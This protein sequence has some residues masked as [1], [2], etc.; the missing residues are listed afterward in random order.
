MPQGPV[1]WL[2]NHFLWNHFPHVADLA[3]TLQTLAL[4]LAC[5]AAHSTMWWAAQDTLLLEF[6][7]TTRPMVIF[8]EE[9]SWMACGISPSPAPSHHPPDP[10]L[11]EHVLREQLGRRTPGPPEPRPWTDWSTT[12]MVGGQAALP[13]LR[14]TC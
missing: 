6:M 1:P 3:P 8:W 14:M 9:G 11:V 4:W 13:F 5:M 2:Q 10:E 12:E 7:P